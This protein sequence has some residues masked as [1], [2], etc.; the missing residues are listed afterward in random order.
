MGMIHRDGKFDVKERRNNRIVGT[1]SLSVLEG[2]GPD[3]QVEGL[4]LDKS[5][6]SLT[7]NNREARV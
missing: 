7:Y 1:I 4:Y 3:A 5:M 2:I 6:D